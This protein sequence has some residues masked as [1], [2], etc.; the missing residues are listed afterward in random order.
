MVDGLSQSVPPENLTV[1]VNTGDDFHHLGLKVC[2]DLDTVVYTLAGL[3]SKQRGW[4]RSGESWRAMETLERIGVPAWFRLGDKDLG[5]HLWRTQML[6]EG[7][8]LSEFTLDLSRSFEITSRVLPMTDD[9]VSTFVQTDEGTLPFQEYFVARR[10]QPSVS[11]FEFRGAG[12][13]RPAPGVLDGIRESEVIVICPSN[14]WVSIDPILAIPGI[15]DALADKPVVAVSPLIGGKAVK[16]PA[17]KMARELGH[18]PGAVT[19]AEHYR[20]VLTGFVLDE[21]DRR[22]EE[23]IAAL[24]ISTH[25]QNTLMKD[26]DDRRRLGTGLIR[27]AESLL[28]GVHP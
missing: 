16:G 6:S 25:V 22:H 12:E 26:R 20:S 18:E 2:P 11:G 8:S 9:Q 23:D 13:A 1:V 15:R 14:P 28:T 5:V 10:C 3:A 17:A 24:G 7:Q 19:V 4:G 27:F 21:Q